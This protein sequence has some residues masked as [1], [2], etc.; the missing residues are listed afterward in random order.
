MQDYFLALLVQWARQGV[1]LPIVLSVGGATI[2]GDLIS[3]DEYFE[4]ISYLVQPSTPDSSAG[5][6]H[7]RELL[8]SIPRAADEAA[9][10]HIDEGAEPEEIRKDRQ[11]MADEYVH[12]K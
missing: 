3:E 8:R 4:G 5:A 2:A 1:S 9:M 7:I 10:M 11:K 12:L 6:E